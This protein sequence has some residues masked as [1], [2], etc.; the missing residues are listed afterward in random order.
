L[1]V[2]VPVHWL[3]SLH[4]RNAEPLAAKGIAVIEHVD[5]V[6]AREYVR[7]AEHV[8]IPARGRYAEPPRRIVSGPVTKVARPGVAKT[9]TALAM[10]PEVGGVPVAEEHVPEA[11]APEDGREGVAC[12][13][14]EPVG[15]ARDAV[16]LP[17]HAVRGRV[18]GCCAGRG[19]SRT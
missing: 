19:T 11:V 3:L 16:P 9:V 8:C 13:S 6:V 17:S 14:A 15:A 18:H 4:H 2:V 12:I 5:L 1:A 10:R 7:I